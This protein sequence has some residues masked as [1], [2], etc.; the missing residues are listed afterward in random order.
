LL[1]VIDSLLVLNDVSEETLHVRSGSGQSLTDE[2]DIDLGIGLKLLLPYHAS[3][4]MMTELLISI[5]RSLNSS[6]DGFLSHRQ[7]HI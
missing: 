6:H 1:S 7:T 2:S 4:H 5:R 3:V